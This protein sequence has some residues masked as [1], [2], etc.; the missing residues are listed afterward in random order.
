MARD[1]SS[2]KIETHGGR[3]E[4][5]RVGYSGAGGTAVSGSGEV[6]RKPPLRR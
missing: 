1:P 5:H 6:S 2:E 3:V 4:K